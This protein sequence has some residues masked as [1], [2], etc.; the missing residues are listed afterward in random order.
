MTNR[1]FGT[2]MGWMRLRSSC[3]PL[4]A[5]L[6]LA[7]APALAE[8]DPLE[9]YRERFQL[10]LERF[11]AGDVHAAI[12]YWEA[13]RRQLG[14]EKAYRLMFNLGKAYEQLGDATLAAERYEVF[15]READVAAQQGALDPAVQ[16]NVATARA[17]MEALAASHARIRVLASARPGLVQVDQGEP[18]LGAFCA[19]VAPGKHTVTVDRDTPKQRS[20]AF[21]L[22]AGQVV[23]VDPTR[24][25]DAPASP[26]PRVTPAPPAQPPAVAVVHEPPFPAYVIAVAGGVTV[27]SLAVPWVARRHAL[28]IRND[29]ED[30]ATSVDRRH[31]L[32]SDYDDAKTLYGLSWLVPVAFAGAT[33]GLT[34][35]YLDGAPVTV[36][37]GPTATGGD[38]RIRG[39]S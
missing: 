19:Y 27:A 34:V 6:L 30:P 37:G 28:G 15:L 16:E 2:T 23:D 21:A 7:V 29:Y 31:E 11:R 38:V 8:P 18:R 39:R 4:C 25:A 20:I 17:R 22:E 26:P 9:P 10:G 33:G 24:P 35:W 5:A 1:R 12:Q 32:A 3:L 36:E 13:I 14:D